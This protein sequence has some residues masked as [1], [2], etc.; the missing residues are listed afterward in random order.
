MRESDRSPEREYVDGVDFELV[1]AR[2]VEVAIGDQTVWFISKED[3]IAAKR[4]CGRPQDL[5]D[6]SALQS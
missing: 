1:W 6:I 4:A 2:R 3:L 5:L